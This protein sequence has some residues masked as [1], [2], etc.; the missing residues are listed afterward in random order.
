MKKENLKKLSGIITA[1]A[2][3]LSSLFVVPISKTDAIDARI[4]SAVHGQ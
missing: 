2:I 1:L 4:E 3:L